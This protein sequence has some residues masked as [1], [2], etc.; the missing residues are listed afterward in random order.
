MQ[1]HGY[2]IG[3]K[4][5]DRI[6]QLNLFLVNVQSALILERG[7][8]FLGGNGAEHPSAFS[9]LHLNHN[10]FALQILCKSLS[11]FQYFFCLLF[12]VGI[13]QLQVIQI[14]CIGFQTQLF[15]QYKVSGIAVIYIYNL[16]LFPQ[17]FYIF[18]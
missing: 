15:R 6:S 1:L 14:L 5:F 16:T 17:G 12:F 13:L 4:C 7:S 2:I 8:Y 3:P 11:R 10:G 9:G 18:Q